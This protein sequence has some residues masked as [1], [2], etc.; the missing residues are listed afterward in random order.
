M[1]KILITVLSMAIVLLALWVVPNVTLDTS[2]VM[3][4]LL[5]NGKQLL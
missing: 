2:A 4:V 3:E 1:R 5:R